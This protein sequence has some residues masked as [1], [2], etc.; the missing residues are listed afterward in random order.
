MV[1]M[2]MQVLAKLGFDG[3][4]GQFRLLHNW[5]ADLQSELVLRSELLLVASDAKCF[6]IAYGH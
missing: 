2:G 4:M 3:V 5:H 1:Y 6:N